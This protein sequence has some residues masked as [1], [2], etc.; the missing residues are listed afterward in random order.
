VAAPEVITPKAQVYSLQDLQQRY[1]TL[2]SVVFADCTLATE[3]IG[4]MPADAAGVRLFV[5][6]HLKLVDQELEDAVKRIM[7][8]EI[9][10]RDVPAETG[11]LKE[12]LSYGISVVRRD[13]NGPWLG[14]WMIKACLKAAAS[15]LG[16]FVQKRG[17]KGDVAEMGQMSAN[18]VSR[19]DVARPERVYLCDP[20]G[21][22][23]AE[24]YFQS[25]RGRVQSPAGS[26]S[27]VN[28]CE[29]VAAGSRFGFEFRFYPARI[30]ADDIADIF[31]SAMIIGLG[32]G[33]A[34]ERG[35]FSINSLTF[36]GAEG[37]KKSGSES[38]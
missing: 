14:N 15:R 11:E 35:K 7:K 5:A 1:R 9:G 33:K 3:L 26:K 32:S 34:F 6:H 20:T 29:C 37:K 23:P 17:S 12:K 25:F 38:S 16:I 31:A 24:T 18:G 10:E 8:E 28:D 13:A 27:I 19:L 36:E 22:A 30:K 21:K 4:G 2:T